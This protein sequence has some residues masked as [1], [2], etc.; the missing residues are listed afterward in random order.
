MRR[1]EVNIDT[2]HTHTHTY[3]YTHTQTQAK[4]ATNTQAVQTTQKC[5]IIVEKNR[6]VTRD[7]LKKHVQFPEGSQAL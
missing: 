5:I 3:R 4:Q 2:E 6:I 1:L 7:L